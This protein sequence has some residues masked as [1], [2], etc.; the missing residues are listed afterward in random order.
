MS[1]QIHKCNRKEKVAG[2]ERGRDNVWDV[3]EDV[4]LCGWRR[5]Q[6]GKLPTTGGE[7]VRGRA[8]AQ[9]TRA[10]VQAREGAGGRRRSATRAGGWRDGRVEGAAGPPPSHR[11]VLATEQS[12]GLPSQH[13]T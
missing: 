3:T 8:G 4:T 9:G 5:C 10:G 7:E 12:R 6:Q 13:Q 11:V 2:D 1:V